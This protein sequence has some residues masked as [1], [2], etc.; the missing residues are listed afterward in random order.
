METLIKAVKDHAL[1]NYE[2][3]WDEV[4]EAWCDDDIS[5][6]IG[7]ATSIMEA[8]INVGVVVGIRNDY[9]NEIKA[10]AF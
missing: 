10:T 6:A 8:I 1:A 7:E 5:E 9:A 4:V 3:G 2:N